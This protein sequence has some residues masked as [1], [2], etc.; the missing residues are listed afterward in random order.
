MRKHTIFGIVMLL[1]V[2][3]M[4]LMPVVKAASS[5]YIWDNIHFVEGYEGG[6][7]IKYPHPDR[8]Y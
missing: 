4:S 1:L 3:L 6:E 2:S 7:W 5:S 8:L